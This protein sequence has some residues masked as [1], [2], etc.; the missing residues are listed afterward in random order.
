MDKIDWIYFSLNKH[1][2]AIEILNVN[3]DKINWN[4]LCVNEN[5]KIIEILKENYD[6]INW[7]YL[8][9]NKNAIEL[10]KKN[11][12]KIYWTNLSLNPMATEILR[13]NIDKLHIFI[14]KNPCIFELDYNKMR[15]NF[16]EMEEEIIKEVLH[17]RRVIRNLEMYGYDID[18]MFIF[19]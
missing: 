15:I 5:P 12:D 16:E 19:E 8:S 10:L 2:D 6:K 18:D 3:R 9:S 7:K 14:Y 4:Y 1:N 13:E 11:I 17:P